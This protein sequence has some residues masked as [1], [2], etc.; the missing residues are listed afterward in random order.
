MAPAP[1]VDTEEEAEER[2]RNYEQQRKE[3]QEEQE[4]RAEARRQEDERQQ[5]E[6]EAERERREKLQKA[7][8]AKF[9]R[10][11][12]TA[13]AMF[14][15]N[16]LRAFLKLLVNLDPYTFTDD[17]AEHFAI[18]H[19][20]SDKTSEEILLSALDGLAD[21]K[22]TG[23][24]LRLVLTQHSSIPREGEIDLLVEAEA[25]FATPEPKKTTSKK[26]KKPTPLKA[27]K[28]KKTPANKE[29]AA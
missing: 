23:F 26:V 6:N 15:S 25:A 20:D 24:A 9:E 28:S 10:I 13:P 17:V 3:Y 12:D 11:L 21:Y 7:R 4:R 22:L 18:E 1:E 29:V 19:E 2:Q 14:S 8:L 16:Q 27:S 5:Q